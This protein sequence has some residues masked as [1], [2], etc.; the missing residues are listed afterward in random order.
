MSTPIIQ[1]PLGNSGAPIRTFSWEALK[2]WLSV[3]LPLMA[4]TLCLS[5]IFRWREGIQ[6]RKK[7]KGHYGMDSADT[8]V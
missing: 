1:W 3:T 6:A 5:K 4:V 2:I 8:Q 7:R